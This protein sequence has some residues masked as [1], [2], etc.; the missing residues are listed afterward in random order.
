MKDISFFNIVRYNDNLFEYPCVNPQTDYLS[1]KYVW[2]RCED[3]P[4]EMLKGVE[5]KGGS[6]MILKSDEYIHNQP[7]PYAGIIFPPKI[8]EDS[9]NGYYE[10][11]NYYIKFSQMMVHKLCV[12]KPFSHLLFILPPNSTECSMRLDRMA[13]FALSGLVQGLGKIYA[14]KGLF[15]NA[16]VL[17]DNT[18]KEL[19][20]EWITFLISNNSNNM[21]GQIITL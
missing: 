14:P 15:V 12:F 3:E 4:N 17:G 2:V 21:V 16:L 18:D 1:G 20:T 7:T 10:I 13:Y 6:I 9:K 19:T 5:M 11:L 8:S